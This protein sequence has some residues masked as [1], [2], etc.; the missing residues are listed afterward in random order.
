MQIQDSPAEAGSSGEEKKYTQA[1]LDFFADNA[2]EYFAMANKAKAELAA[3]LAV[4]E[5]KDALYVSADRCTLVRVWA[6]GTVECARRDTP[7]H[8]WG[9]PVYLT[10]EG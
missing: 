10:K 5:G 3:A 8:I 9:P 7:D 1:D 2:D 4:S 6:S